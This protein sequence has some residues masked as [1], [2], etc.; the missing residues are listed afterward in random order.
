[1]ERIWGRKPPNAEPCEASPLPTSPNAEPGLAEK[2]VPQLRQAATRGMILLRII[3]IVIITI[4]R[5]AA[6]AMHISA[7]RSLAPAVC[8]RAGAYFRTCVYIYIYIYIYIYNNNRHHH[9]HHHHHH[10]NNSPQLK[11]PCK[12]VHACA[13]TCEM[14]CVP[15]KLPECHVVLPFPVQT[16][17]DDGLPCSSFAGFILSTVVTNA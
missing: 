15:R 8:A 16:S 2:W 12:S 10:H 17:F 11:H 5:G 3:I 4:M 13:S 1:M 9:H 14:Y 7:S 6:A